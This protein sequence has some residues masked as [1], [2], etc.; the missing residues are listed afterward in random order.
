MTGELCAEWVRGWEAW[1][2]GLDWAKNLGDGARLPTKREAALLYANLP[3]EFGKS[4]WHW[5]S[6]PY[7]ASHAWMQYFLNGFQYDGFQR[8]ERLCR[9]VR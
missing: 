9:A 1:H 3:D 2:A 4:D 7:S 8:S 6:T 5:T